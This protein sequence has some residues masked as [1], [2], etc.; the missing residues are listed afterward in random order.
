[1]EIQCA[2]ATLPGCVDV[3]IGTIVGFGAITSG[4]R[5]VRLYVEHAHPRVSL[6]NH[7]DAWA[8]VIGPGAASYETQWRAALAELE[9]P[10]ELDYLRD[11]DDYLRVRSWTVDD[12]LWKESMPGSSCAAEGVS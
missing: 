5:D 9:H 10:P 7:H 8:P 1:E 12:P 4:L 6:P 11:P 3:Q 2:L